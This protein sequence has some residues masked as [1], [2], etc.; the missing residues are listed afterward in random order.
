[1]AATP[2]PPAA[3]VE[4]KAS[5]LAKMDANVMN[6]AAKQ[7]E[8]VALE[9][10]KVAVIEAECDSGDQVSCHVLSKEDDA[11]RAWLSK[12]DAASWGAAAA[13]ITEAAAAPSM[14]EDAAKRA[15]LARLDTS[16][17]GNAAAALSS[18][19]AEAAQMAAMEAACD[20]GDDKACDT[21]SREEAAKLEWLAKLSERDLTGLDALEELLRAGALTREEYNTRQAALVLTL[22]LSNA[23]VKRLDVLNQ[24]LGE[25]LLTREEYDA[26]LSNFGLA[27]ALSQSDQERL[28]KLDDLLEHGY[29]T[30]EEHTKKR[31]QI[32]LGALDELL[33]AG[34]VSKEEYEAKVKSILAV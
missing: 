13:S 31:A 17:A 1:M 9:A 15:W 29:V 4:A 10:A 3:V 27:P 21:L 12:V 18:V 23:D 20:G 16:K 8:S 32:R 24:L 2:A 33:D 25:G 19:V 11:K 30:R 5:L 22:G 7:I 34:F 14:S 6:R 26:K 28:K